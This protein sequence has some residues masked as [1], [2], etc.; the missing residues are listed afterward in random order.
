M[1]SD[2]PEHIAPLRRW[3]EETGIEAALKALGG[4][5]TK[6]EQDRIDRWGKLLFPAWSRR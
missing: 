3:A 4:S 2:V 1:G 6:M 5:A